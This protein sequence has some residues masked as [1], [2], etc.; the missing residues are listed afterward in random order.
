MTEPE[1]KA[2]H[3]YY[4]GL[5]MQALID[6]WDDD[7]DPEAYRTVICHKAHVIADQMVTAEET[8]RDGR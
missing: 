4:A 6:R 7:R 1:R 8:F 5:A 3:R 2:A